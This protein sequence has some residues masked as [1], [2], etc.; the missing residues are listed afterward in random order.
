MFALKSKKDKGEKLSSHSMFNPSKYLES[1]MIS[2]T[3]HCLHVNRSFA[4]I[5]R[6]QYWYIPYALYC[7]EVFHYKLYVYVYVHVCVHMHVFCFCLLSN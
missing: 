4:E 6:Y 3:K 2:I 5:V 1:R 7:F